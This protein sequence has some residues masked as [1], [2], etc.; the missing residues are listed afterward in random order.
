MDFESATEFSK[1]ASA[2][3]YVCSA[4]DAKLSNTTNS[5]MPMDRISQ[6]KEPTHC[7]HVGMHHIAEEPKG[8]YLL[9]GGGRT[10]EDG[11]NWRKYG[12]KPVKGSEHTRSYYKCTHPSCKMKKKVEQSHDSQ[13]TEIIY[14]GGH[15]H[16]K[17]QPSRRSALG[18][19]LS[20]CEMSGSGESEGGSIWKNIQPGSKQNLRANAWERISSTSSVSELSNSLSNTPGQSIGILESA[21]TPELSSTVLASQDDVE[22]GTTQGSTILGDDFDD[23]DSESRKRCL[24]FY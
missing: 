15:N 10:S 5:D 9:T 2:K 8:T 11:Y 4:T 18:S 14:K 7:E 24:E 1:E 12:Q 23:E 17:P 19:A 20:F 6:Y 22:D 13:I 16:P 21:G 3:N